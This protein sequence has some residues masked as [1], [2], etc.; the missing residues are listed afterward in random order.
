MKATLFLPTI[1]LSLAS[2]YAVQDMQGGNNTTLAV[3]DMQGVNDTTHDAAVTAAPAPVEFH[4]C[5]GFSLHDSI[6]DVTEV[7]LDPN[8]P[9]KKQSVRIVVRGH[10][11]ETVEQGAYVKATVKKGI[12]HHTLD[13]D[14]CKGIVAG[15]PV[16]AGDVEFWTGQYIAGFIPK[17]EALIRVKPF[18]KDKRPMGCIEV[19]INLVKA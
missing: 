2:A 6:F 17:G 9:R 3:Q 10:L 13:F 11:N 1:L 5:K 12:L 18:T 7:T 19:P 15:C 16:P 8:P 14:F 4:A